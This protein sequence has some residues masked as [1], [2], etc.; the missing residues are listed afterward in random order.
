MGIPAGCHRNSSAC[1]FPGCSLLLPE[2]TQKIATPSFFTMQSTADVLIAAAQ[3]AGGAAAQALPYTDEV[4]FIQSQ[5]EPLVGQTGGNFS[6]PEYE[7]LL[8]LFP[9][10]WRLVANEPLLLSPQR[11][12]IR[13]GQRSDQCRLRGLPGKGSFSSCRFFRRPWAKQ[14]QTNPGCSSWAIQPQQ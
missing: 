1:Y 14:G 9:T 2:S 7:F 5:L 4:A 8:C 3:V 11:L 12:L 10:V 13:P 6:A